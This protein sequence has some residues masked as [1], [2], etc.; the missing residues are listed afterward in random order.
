MPKTY[1]FYGVHRLG[2]EMYRYAIALWE[3]LGEDEA[4]LRN[5]CELEHKAIQKMYPD[6]TPE[7]VW[8]GEKVTEPDFQI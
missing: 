7:F 1:R 3:V 8:Y 2:P 4:T 5:Q 6:K